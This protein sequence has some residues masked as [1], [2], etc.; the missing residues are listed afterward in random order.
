MNINKEETEFINF[1]EEASETVLSDDQIPLVHE[2][3]QRLGDGHSV[4]D[5]IEE[6]SQITE[7]EGLAN[8]LKVK[9]KIEDKTKKLHM[10]TLGLLDGI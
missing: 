5:F 6:A 3:I 8:S 10:L 1:L 7:L 4:K 2:L 9:F